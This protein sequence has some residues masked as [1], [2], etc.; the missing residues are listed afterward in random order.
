M[1]VFFAETTEE[2]RGSLSNTAAKKFQVHDGTLL[3]TIIQNEK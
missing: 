1:Y 3:L 2:R